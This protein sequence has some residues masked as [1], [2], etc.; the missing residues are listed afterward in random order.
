[1]GLVYNMFLIVGLY[2]SALF[3]FAPV[4]PSSQ[5]SSSRLCSEL[6]FKA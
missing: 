3:R 6:S 2:Y 5:V 4:T 1:M